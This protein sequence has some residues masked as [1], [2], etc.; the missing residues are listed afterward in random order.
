MAEGT[1]TKI[2]SNFYY[3]DTGSSV[4]ECKARGK[5]KKDCITPLVG[6]RVKISLN[7][8]SDGVIDQV[9]ERK[10][11]FL[12]PPV[13][14]VD[15]VVIIISNT[16]PV[17]VPFLIDQLTAIVDSS[18][19]E[20]IICINKSDVDPGDE[21]YD[22]Y[23]KAGF[24]V[25]RTSASTGEGICELISH[26]Q[27]KLSVFTGNSGVG[28]SSILNSIDPGFNLKVADVSQKLGRGRHTTRHTEIFSLACGAKV[29][30]TPGFSSLD[31]ERVSPM[32]KE[33]VQYAFR[34][35]DDYI[36]TCRFTDCSH[37][38]E[39]GCSIRDAVEAGKISRSRYGSYL[40]LYEQAK[41]LKEWELAGKK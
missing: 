15:Q 18:G 23:S 37:T 12:R 10:N 34:E 27:G 38:K 14:N 20:C 35:F 19:C 41:G 29:A 24:I 5:F 31:I 25:V 28:K 21:L 6:D 3:V 9:L 36:G 39:Q 16:I 1:I 33:D 7:S 40:R 30:D 17:A 4:V 11:S 32:L 2:L 8:K 22:I 13:A 26:I